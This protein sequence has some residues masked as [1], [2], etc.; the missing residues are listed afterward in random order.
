M[1]GYGSQDKK[2]I[3]SLHCENYEQDQ[4]RKRKKQHQIDLKTNLK[5]K[6]CQKKEITISRLS[7]KL[8]SP[9]PENV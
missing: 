4:R 8:V 7:R 6:S 5:V 1:S 2:E 3:V 9:N